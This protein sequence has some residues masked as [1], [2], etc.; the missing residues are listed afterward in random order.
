M[1]TRRQFL[2]RAP[3]G[4]LVAASA[5]R[6]DSRPT[7]SQSPTTAGAPP[8]WGTGPGAG[9]PVTP[10]TFAEAE[11]LMQIT[12]TE[13]ERQQA[14]DS[15][16]QLLAPYL[17]RRSGP[18]KVTIADTDAP[19]TL[20]NPML[21]GLI[22][23]SAPD[24]FVRSKADGKPLPPSDDGIAFAPVSQ[25]SRWIEGRQLTSERLTRIYLSRIERLDPKSWRSGGKAA[26]LGGQAQSLF[27][28]ELRFAIRGAKISLA[29]SQRPR[30]WCHF[31]SAARRAEASLARRCAVE[32]R[33]RRVARTGAMTLCWSL[34]N[35]DDTNSMLVLQAING[36]DAGDASSVPSRLDFDATAPVAKVGY[37]PQWM[38]ERPATD[39][40]RAQ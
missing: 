12:M 1:N 4:F 3:L 13:P 21:P 2:L 14:A 10:A 33:P 15:W 26:S 11:K 22:Q 39:V 34:D 35:S 37:V 6:D 25:Q 24:R 30:L 16:R 40:D 38:K 28:I 5:C 9:P 27:V 20:W 31:P 17:E 29:E 19:A 8:T 32:F 18:R 7:S 23:P 36:P